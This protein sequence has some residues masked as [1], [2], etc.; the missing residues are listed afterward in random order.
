VLAPGGD[1]AGPDYLDR[2]RRDEAEAEALHAPLAGIARASVRRGTRRRPELLRAAYLVDRD[3]VARFV[4]A[5]EAAQAA[6]PQL[7]LLCTGPW[8]PYSFTTP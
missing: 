6:N 4:R 1:E 8:P 3:A 7:S 2:R 5:V